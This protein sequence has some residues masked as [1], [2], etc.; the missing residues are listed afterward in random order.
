LPKLVRHLRRLGCEVIR[1]GAKHSIFLNPQ[2]RQTAPV[3][4]HAE[5]DWRVACEICRELGIEP[6]SER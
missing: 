4:R 2:N 6:P 1:E 3:P 5:I